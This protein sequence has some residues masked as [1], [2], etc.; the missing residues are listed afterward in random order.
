MARF[1]TAT[2]RSA[3]IERVIRD[4]HGALTLISAFVFPRIVHLQRLQDA[5]E[6]GVEITILF[7][8]KPMDQGVFRDLRELP[9]M[10]LYFLKELH[11]KC[12][13][14]ER[15]GV[16]TSLNLLGGSERH[17]REMGVLLSAAEDVEAYGA[18]CTEARTDPRQEHGGHAHAMGAAGAGDNHNTRGWR[19]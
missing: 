13:F 9:N 18:M 8:K 15:E 11:A 12:Y 3:A 1:L 6:R 5:A 14:N 10:R 4:A 2:D 7:G 16:I 17:N 19:R